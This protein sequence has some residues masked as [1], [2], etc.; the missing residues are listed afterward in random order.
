MSRMNELSCS[1]NDLKTAVSLLETVIETLNELFTAEEPA[2]AAPAPKPITKEE[3]RA[4]LA[5]KTSQG[6][7][8][9]VRALL[10]KFGAAQLSAVEPD[11][12][13]SLMLQAQAI[14]IE[15]GVDG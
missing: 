5:A 2:P 15:V 7:G 11:H 1:M 13:H 14:G 12:Y 10:K 9:Q 4:V 3:V 8:S 6:Y